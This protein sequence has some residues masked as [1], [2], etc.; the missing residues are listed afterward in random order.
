MLLNNI[1]KDP[2]KFSIK[3]LD[4]ISQH[5]VPY[6]LYVPILH[7][8]AIKIT[9]DMYPVKP[10]DRSQ[11]YKVLFQHDTRPFVGGIP[12]GRVVRNP[13]SEQHRFICK[14]LRHK[15]VSAWYH[16]PIHLVFPWKNHGG[17]QGAL[18][19]ATQSQ[20]EF[21]EKY[22]AWR[23]QYR[24]HYDELTDA[25]FLQVRVN[26]FFSECVFE[27]DLDDIPALFSVNWFLTH[28]AYKDRWD[29]T[30]YK[31]SLRQRDEVTGKPMKDTSIPRLL[32][33]D[34]PRRLYVDNNVLNNRRYNLQLKPPDEE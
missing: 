34:V 15:L 28:H 23:N 5:L 11:L 4:A 20:K 30:K 32:F 10:P 26:H 29:E 21:T 27:C 3:V 31:Y 24:V 13:E 6:N 33:P 8:Q 22:G 9:S 2:K 7:V 18:E 1:Y 19:A 25:Y 12:V 16:P 17:E 14:Q